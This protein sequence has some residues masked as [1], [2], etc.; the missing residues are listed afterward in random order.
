[1][2]T[3][4]LGDRSLFPDLRV[5]AYLNHAAISPLSLPARQ[6]AERAIAD[7]AQA[8]S[9]AFPERLFERQKLRDDLARL[10][11][12]DSDEIALVPSTGYGLAALATSFPW[13]RGARVIVFA[14]EYPTNVSV[15][16]QACARHALQLT[17]LPVADLARPDAADFSAL[18]R[19]LRRGDVQLCAASTVQFQTGLRMPIERMAELC[20]AHG[21]QLAVDAVQGLGSVP[22]DVRALGVDYAA[23]GSHKWLMG[24]DGAG[25][26]FIKA[27]HLP[28]LAPSVAG[29]FSHIDAELIFAQAGQLRYDRGLRSDA[30]VFEGGMLSSISLSTL[31]AS[32]PIL[33][34]LGVERIYA[35][36]NTYLDALEAGLLER[37]FHSLRLADAARRSCILGVQLPAAAGVSA[38]RFATELVTRGVICSAPDAVLRFAP[39]F[40]CGLA[41]VS[42]VLAAI[43]DVLAQL[44]SGRGTDPR[45]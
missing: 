6:A 4:V 26:L 45:S 39:H 1:M 34:G 36:V 29:A 15:W 35:H 21:A 30:R 41:E 23:A 17:M 9:V 27:E 28:Q 22:L 7:L 24:A 13:R 12:A 44:R 2:N 37:G 43:D 3:A 25:V 11:G 8:G 20:H 18:E 32:V 10:L 38:S 31:S 5:L 16:Q 33:L 19:E 40:H 14:G 42:H